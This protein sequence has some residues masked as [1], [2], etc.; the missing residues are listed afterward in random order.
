MNQG[1]KTIKDNLVQK[2]DS[3]SKEMNKNTRENRE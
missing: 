3:Y 1:F 2:Q